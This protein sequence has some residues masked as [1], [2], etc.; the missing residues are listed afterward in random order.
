MWYE[1]TGSRNGSS[2]AVPL[3][4]VLW[5]RYWKQTQPPRP[6][7]VNGSSTT[8]PTKT[9]PRFWSQSVGSCIK[10][11]YPLVIGIPLVYDVFWRAGISQAMTENGAIR[12]ENLASTEWVRIYFCIVVES[13]VFNRQVLDVVPM[14]KN[15]G[16]GGMVWPKIPRVFCWVDYLECGWLL[17]TSPTEHLQSCQMQSVFLCSLRISQMLHFWF[18]F[19]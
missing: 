16:R 1:S 12:V 10:H 17:V 19:A 6:S 7:R 14:Q 13:P 3:W 9:G 4:D 18:C 15:F 8:V 2:G 11:I 5:A